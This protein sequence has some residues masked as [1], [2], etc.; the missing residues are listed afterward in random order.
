MVN[1]W[2]AASFNREFAF[3]FSTVG[4]MMQHNSGKLSRVGAIMSTMC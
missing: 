3:G 2:S 4:C 1:E